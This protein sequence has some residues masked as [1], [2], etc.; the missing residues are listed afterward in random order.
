[1]GPTEA[2]A[3]RKLERPFDLARTG[4]SHEAKT[5]LTMYAYHFRWS[6]RM[7]QGKNAKE[8]WL[9]RTPA[10]AASL[11]DAERTLNGLIEAR[12]NALRTVMLQ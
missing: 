8:K 7:L 4:E 10:L 2:A 12:G 3:A 6:V 5:H 9:K 11:T 1:M